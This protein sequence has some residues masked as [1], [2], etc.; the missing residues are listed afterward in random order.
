MCLRCLVVLCL[1]SLFRCFGTESSA[2]TVSRGDSG[3]ISGDGFPLQ[4]INPRHIGDTGAV[5]SVHSPEHI[6]DG[7]QFKAFTVVPAIRQVN[8]ARFAV[9]GAQS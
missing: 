8:N 9:T 2:I 5:E 3:V 6:V 1:V 7:R 4:W